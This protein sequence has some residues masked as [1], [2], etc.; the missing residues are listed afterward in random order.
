MRYATVCGGGG[1]TMKMSK[2]GRQFTALGIIAVLAVWCAPAN[3]NESVRAELTRLQKQ[4]GLSLVALATA[5]DPGGNAPRSRESIDAVVFGRQSLSSG[6]QLLP[7]DAR[8]SD[9]G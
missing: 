7:P 4:K 3:A 6:K 1:T 9:N 8:I 5:A 2:S